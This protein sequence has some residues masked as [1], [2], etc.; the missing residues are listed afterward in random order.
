[1]PNEVIMHSYICS[2]ELGFGMV[3]SAKAQS[4]YNKSGIWIGLGR[5]NPKKSQPIQDIQKSYKSPT[6]DPKK[7]SNLPRNPKP[8]PN[9]PKLWDFW[10]KFGENVHTFGIFGSGVGLLGF[11]GFGCAN[12][13]Q[14]CTC[15]FTDKVVVSI[16][17]FDSF[18]LD[19]K[20]QFV[21][22]LIYIDSIIFIY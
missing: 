9:I 12:S 20:Y 13:T 8:K 5:A 19:S 11:L 16:V 10:V 4:S 15:T 22:N 6:S 17:N 18:L 1:M 21:Y 3:R 7:S 14:I 2:F